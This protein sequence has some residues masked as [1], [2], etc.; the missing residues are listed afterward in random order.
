M[1]WVKLVSILSDND[2]EHNLSSQDIPNTALWG[3]SPTGCPHIGYLPTIALLKHLK[4]LGANIL[5]LIADYHAYMDSEKTPWKDLDKKTTEYRT[6]FKAYGFGE[7]IVILSEIYTRKNY[8]NSFYEFSRYLPS[9]ELINAAKTTLK[10][11]FTKEYRF[12]D[13]LY[14]ATQIHDVKYF[15][16]DFVISGKDECGIYKLGLPI[17]SKI[18]NKKY[19]FAYLPVIPGLEQKEMH[20]TDKASNKITLFDDRNTIENKIRTYLLKCLE[21]NTYPELVRYIENIIFPLF[22]FDKNV[23]LLKMLN[24]LSK[25]NIEVI[26][27]DL[28]LQLY[29]ILRPIQ[30]SD[31]R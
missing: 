19:F 11:Y 26:S 27:K 25:D 5:L 8:V 31:G 14:V 17:L 18:T 30:E 16:V 28:A 29:N 15:N 24:N 20:A 2:V 22:E 9:I 4:S 7:D 12:S 23:N 6:V 3:V 21:T 13:F 10:S 1:E